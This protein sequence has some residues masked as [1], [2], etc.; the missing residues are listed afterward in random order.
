MWW[1]TPLITA[2]RSQGQVILCESKANLVCKFYAIQNYP[3]S[4]QNHKTSKQANKETETKRLLDILE[5][6]L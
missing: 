4:K 6:E 2:L 3:V 1:H 5:P